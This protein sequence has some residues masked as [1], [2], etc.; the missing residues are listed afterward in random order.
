MI[1]LKSNALHLECELRIKS[2]SNLCG[3]L[4]NKNTDSS[5]LKENWAH[6]KSHTPLILRWTF[7]EIWKYEDGFIDGKKSKREG[8]RERYLAKKCEWITSWT[9]CHHVGYDVRNDYNNAHVTIQSITFP[10]YPPPASQSQ[11]PSS[12]IRVYQKWEE[13]SRST[14][15][16]K[17]MEGKIKG[18][19]VYEWYQ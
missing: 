2:K 15:T 14:T 4:L 17:H 1:S 16:I 13:N 12:D 7:Y 10:M 19:S 6:I 18:R 11:I 9:C 5:C 3:F 8:G